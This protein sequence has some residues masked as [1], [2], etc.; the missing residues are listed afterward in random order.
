[1][2]L[3]LKLILSGMAALIPLY[4]AEKSYLILHELSGTGKLL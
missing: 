3:L 4:L 1:M 2:K